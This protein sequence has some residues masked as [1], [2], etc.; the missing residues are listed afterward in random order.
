MNDLI[1]DLEEEIKQIETEINLLNVERDRLIR[2]VEKMQF[3]KIISEKQIT[4]GQII[5]PYSLAEWFFTP[6]N[7]ILWIRTH[8]KGSPEKYLA[9]N[10]KLYDR[11]QAESTG[12]MVEIGVKFDDLDE[13]PA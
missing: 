4:R 5:D 1:K 12:K 9:W 6:E 13:V 8:K 7:F 3:E 2:R 10:G 11:F